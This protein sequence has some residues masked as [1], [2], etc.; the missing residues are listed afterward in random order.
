[1]KEHTV[2]AG[3]STSSIAALH[4]LSIE[5]LLNANPRKPRIVA[6][7]GGRPTHVFAAL[8]EGERLS[9]DCGCGG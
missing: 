9:T 1:M 8:A 2:R 5:Q 7:V 3:E 6:Y 4:G